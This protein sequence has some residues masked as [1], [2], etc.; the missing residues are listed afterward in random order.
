MR[1]E[2]DMRSTEKRPAAFAI[3]TDRTRRA[4]V[5]V[6]RVEI[7]TVWADF[8]AAMV[9]EKTV[10]G[11]VPHVLGFERLAQRRADIAKKLR[12]LISRPA[13]PPENPPAHDMA[14]VGAVRTD[15]I[16]AKR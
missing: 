12:A 2:T 1:P 7:E 8:E 9:E 6:C 14:G 11:Y 15:E 13:A 16:T 5:R 10:R 4:L 3:V